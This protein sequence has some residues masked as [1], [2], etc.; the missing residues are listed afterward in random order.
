VLL[1]TLSLTPGDGSPVLGLPMITEVSTAVNPLTQLSAE[2]AKLN[3]T[4]Y[5]PATEILTFRVLAKDGFSVWPGRLYLHCRY[6]SPSR[7]T[8][9]GQSSLESNSML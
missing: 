9:L 5:L 4:R 6:C 7:P 3:L 1:A 8:R 2:T